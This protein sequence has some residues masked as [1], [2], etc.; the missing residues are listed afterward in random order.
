[1]VSEDLKKIIAGEVSEDEAV[2]KEA[3]HD[4]SIFELTPQAVIFPKNV[5][6]VQ[7]VVQYAN[8]KRLAHENVSI[9]ARAAGTDM[10][11]GP[12]TT[13]LVL[14]FTKHFN[15]IKEV[16]ENYAVV[17]PGVFYRDL[18]KKMDEKGLFFPSYPASKN[19]CAL[20]GM[21]ANNAGGEKT[22]A[23]GKTAKY[24]EELKVV[25]GDGKE[26][27]LKPLNERELQE[28]IS[29]SD[30]EA[31]IYKKTYE[32]LENNFDLIQ[33]AKPHVSKNSA[34]YALWDVWDRKTF[35]LTKLFVGSQGTLGIITE[36][37]IKLLK[38]KPFVKLVVVFMKDL[39]V[40]S[41]F[42]PEVLKVHPESFESYDQ[43]TL[44][45][46]FQFL[47]DLLKVLKNETIFSMLWGFLPEVW[48]ALR[49]GLP[50]LVVM[51][52]VAGEEEEDVERRAEQVLKEAKIFGLPA[53]ITKSVREANRFWAIRRESF[54]LLRKRVRGKQT[55]PFIDDIIVPPLK[56]PEFLPKLDAILKQYSQYFTYTVAGHIGDGNFHIIPLM[57]LNDEDARKII[58]ILSDEVYDLVLKF[59]GSITAEHNDGLIRSP[60]LVKMFG[61][62][63]MKLF[64]EVKNIFDPRGIF[65]PG[66][67]VHASMDYALRHIK[68]PMA[69]QT[70]PNPGA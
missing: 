66:K 58:P 60:Y 47:P 44:R 7:A 10:S 67:K 68:H 54:N 36:G 30:F 21:L 64:E 38:K 29:G 37:K 55:A 18:E 14:S 25:L 22:L 1:V 61:G 70:G 56:L 40:I 48:M 9:T 28:K 43:H 63:I 35:D 12:L 69:T 15:H 3:S 53:H 2:L 4:A 32:L 51:V 16:G 23:Y 45:L 6:D 65:N 34:G 8:A 42:V 31:Q 49:G 27:V 13:S 52:E 20:G 59:G 39:K 19:L 5:H 11:G 41:E 57:D 46:A 62:E 33:R 26:Y 24:V 50:N 17:E